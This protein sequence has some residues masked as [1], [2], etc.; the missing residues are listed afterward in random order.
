MTCTPPHTYQC[1]GRANPLGIDARMEKCCIASPAFWHY[2]R[3]GRGA[4]GLRLD[5]A[6]GQR[7]SQGGAEAPHHGRPGGLESRP[8][9]LTSGLVPK[10]VNPELE[11]LPVQIYPG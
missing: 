5:H 10:A 7:N 6:P 8:T 2:R 11:F 9:Q 1:R 3:T 4:V